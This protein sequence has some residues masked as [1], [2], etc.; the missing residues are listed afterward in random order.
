MF[1]DADHSYDG[2]KSDLES[3]FQKVKFGGLISG[4]DY[5]NTEYPCF[6]VE[7]A[8]DEFSGKYGYT[9]EFGENFTYFMIKN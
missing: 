6:G 4:H 5:K 9:V 7:R 2:C 3:W 1:I 8:V